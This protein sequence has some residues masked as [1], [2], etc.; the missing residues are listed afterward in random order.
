MALWLN[1]EVPEHL[2]GFGVD[3]FDMLLGYHSL[4]EELVHEL[5]ACPPTV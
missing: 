1:N 5:A 4:H 2:D 3:N